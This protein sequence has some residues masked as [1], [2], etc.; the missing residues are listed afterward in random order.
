MPTARPRRRGRSRSPTSTSRWRPARRSASSARPAPASR[1]C[2][3]CCCATTRRQTGAIRWGAHALARLHARRAARRAS[4]GCRRSRSCSPR[5]SPT[6]SRWRAPDATRADVEQAARMADLHDDIRRF[7]DGYETLVGERGVTLSG[8]QR[9]RVAIARA[10]L[11]DAPLLLLDDALS[12]VDTGDRGPHPRAPARRPARPHGDHRQPPAVGG[13]RRGPDH[14][15]ARPGASSSAART[16]NS[17]ARDGW[18]A[19]QWRYQQ[20]EASLEEAVSILAEDAGAR[21]R[22]AAERAPRAARATAG[23]RSRCCGAPRGPTAADRTGRRSG[24][25]W[26]ACSRRRADLRQAVH[27]RVPAAARRSTGR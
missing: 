4:R 1:R 20:L 27:R 2:C 11:A 24:S 9:Q 7:P 23:R 8:G 19:A 21:G 22:R 6:T 17:L 12:A 18:Y 3:T 13:R 25:R 15:A 26:R 10:L 14:R 5:R 16:P